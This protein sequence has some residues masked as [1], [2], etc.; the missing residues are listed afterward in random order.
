MI[1]LLYPQILCLFYEL[2]F[3]VRVTAHKVGPK[4]K[5]ICHNSGY[6]GWHP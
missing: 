6:T 1:V 4:N 5:N 2:L 3:I